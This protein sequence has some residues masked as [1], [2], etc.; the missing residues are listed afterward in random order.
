MPPFV[1]TAPSNKHESVKTINVQVARSL[2][3]AKRI[4]RKRLLSGKNKSS[5]HKRA[6]KTTFTVM[7]R[8]NQTKIKHFRTHS[9]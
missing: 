5:S 4:K 1:S 6:A 3:N 8:G 7:Q 2:R 9:L